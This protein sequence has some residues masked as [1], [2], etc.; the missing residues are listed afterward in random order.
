MDIRLEKVIKVI[1]GKCG[2]LGN[3]PIGGG[4][5]MKK[6]MTIGW[7]VILVLGIGRYVFAGS[8]DSPGATTASVS[9]MH[10][11]RDMVFYTARQ[12]RYP[13]G[14][15]YIITGTADSATANTLVDSDLTNYPDD[16]FN[17]CQ[18]AII[19]GTGSNQIRAI[20]DFTSSSG[21]VTVSAN[22][23]TNPDATSTYLIRTFD[24][25]PIKPGVFTGHV[26]T[27]TDN[28]LT[29]TSLRSLY[30]DDYF[31]GCKIKIIQGTGS[32]QIR[33]ISD[34]VATT[35]SGGTFTVST[36]WATNPDATSIYAVY[37]SGFSEPAFGQTVITGTATGGSEYALLDSSDDLGL[38][39]TYIGWHLKLTGGKGAGQERYITS[40]MRIGTTVYLSVEKYWG[41]SNIPDTTTTYELS[42]NNTLD[43]VYRNLTRL[44]ATGQ[45]YTTS[46]A[47]YE[48]GE[49][50]RGAT[51]RYIY[52][53]DGTI[54]TE[55]ENVLT[56]LN[57][58]LMWIRDATK[59]TGSGS[60][61]GGNQNISGALAWTYAVTRC[62]A[63][64][65]A[66]HTA[67]RLPNILELMTIVDYGRSLPSIDTT[68]FPNTYGLTYDTGDYWSSTVYPINYSYA[69]RVDFS[70]G[71]VDSP[72][73]TGIWT[74]TYYVRCCRGGSVY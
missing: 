44:P 49:E 24:G 38:N 30:V 62:A 14:G 20:S 27:A 42:R 13:M 21:T 73:M 69:N 36:N 74:N 23:T 50:Q 63:L 31:N 61:A 34:F 1:K 26:G 28:T 46:E 45:T 72:W 15:E 68:A 39:P 59:V 25:K 22:W 6:I 48:D 60:G 66:D 18:I 35:S 70:A 41:I 64:T 52:A 55:A 58:G 4:S 5:K 3:V 51:K 56:D 32:G 2:T 12:D 16:Y 57:T 29:D 11:I 65:Y 47:N 7:M 8:L 33:T 53:D 37:L 17:S 19:G 9:R 10:T 67:W 54:D 43:D 71:W 40:A